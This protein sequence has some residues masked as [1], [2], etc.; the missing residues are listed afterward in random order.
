MQT[1]LRPT[2]AVPPSPSADGLAPVPPVTLSA[3][4]VRRA[5]IASVIGNGLES[6]SYTH[7]TLPTIY[8]V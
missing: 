1:T 5:V 8:S 6:V 3:A 4:Q 7:L 2:R